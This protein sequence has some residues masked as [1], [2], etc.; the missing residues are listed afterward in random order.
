M[1]NR[2]KNETVVEDLYATLWQTTSSLHRETL[3]IVQPCC[4]RLR[5]EKGL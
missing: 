2:K 4:L 5:L 3:V 1:G